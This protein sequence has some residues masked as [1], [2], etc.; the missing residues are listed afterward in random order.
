M[1]MRMG[2]D[3]RSQS[4]SFYQ[5]V[6]FRLV[7]FRWDGARWVYELEYPDYWWN[8]ASSIPPFDWYNG[9]DQYM[10]GD[11]GF[12]INS[13]GYY[14]IAVRYHWWPNTSGGRLDT[15]YN[16]AGVHQTGFYSGTTCLYE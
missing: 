7:L 9:N 15:S 11:Q 10:G 2:P 5:Y 1:Y 14:A 3:M 8:N 13:A 6:A 16:W 12:E 4:A